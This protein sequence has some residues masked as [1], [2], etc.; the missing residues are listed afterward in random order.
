M[1]QRWLTSL[2]TAT[3][4][5]AGAVSVWQTQQGR[6]LAEGPK[7]IPTAPRW[8]KP[9]N[10]QPISKMEWRQQGNSGNSSRY[11]RSILVKWIFMK[12]TWSRE[13]RQQVSP[14]LYS[15]TASAGEKKR[16]WDVGIGAGKE[17]ENYLKAA[18]SSCMGLVIQWSASCHSVI[19]WSASWSDLKK[20]SIY[21]S[22]AQ[23]DNVWFCLATDWKKNQ[24]DLANDAQIS[25]SSSVFSPLITHL[26]I[27]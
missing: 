22:V 19:Q 8:S 13:F 26:N 17:S 27:K 25:P 20:H 12:N 6:H 11:L 24:V 23:A 3:S 14:R 7:S 16:K 5:F 15:P 21:S 2:N 4:A 1:N 10:T 18:S 9:P